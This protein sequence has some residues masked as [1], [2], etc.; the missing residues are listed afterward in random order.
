LSLAAGLGFG[1]PTVLAKDKVL[2]APPVFVGV[3]DAGPTWKNTKELRK[4]AETGNPLACFQYAQLLEVGDQVEKD[5]E[6]AFQFY[7]KAA[8]QNHP[9]ALFRVGTIYHDGL[10]GQTPNRKLGFE[11]YEKAAYVGSLEGTYN[12][13]AML[14]SGR[15]IKRDYEEGLAWLMLAAERGTDP[16]SVEQVRKRLHR[17]PERIERGERRFAVLKKE[18]AA[19][20][21]DPDAPV[22]EKIAPV[23]PKLAKP[24][25]TTPKIG[26]PSLPGFSPST[27]GP[28][29]SAP[30]ISIPK[31]T[32]KPIPPPTAD[33]E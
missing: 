3:D 6:A 17:Y 24:S 8:F 22:E 18:I 1:A 28:K 16:G 5:E 23:A 13:G 27:I 14:V 7:R 33:S 15:G 12:V 10:L 11:Y 29:I 9:E 2:T 32:P 31:P 26:G 30:T 25:I 4:A 20:R 21:M 19:G